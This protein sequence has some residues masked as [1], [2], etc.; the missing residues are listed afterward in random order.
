M[1]L[2]APAELLADCQQAAAD[3]VEHARLAYGIASAF[4]G[5]PIGPGPLSLDGVSLDADPATVLREVVIEGCI[6]ETIGAVEAAEAARTVAD[7]GI[8]A[9]CARIAEDELRHAA[10]GWRT[11]R[12]LLACHPELASVASEAFTDGIRHHTHGIEPSTG[13]IRCWGVAIR[14][15]LRRAAIA[16]VIAPLAERMLRDADPE[17]RG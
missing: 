3:E 2:G 8:A 4:A 9:A 10:L 15:D 1:A 6:G 13:D 16:E 7:A 17:E 5:E 14:P 12:W 11:A